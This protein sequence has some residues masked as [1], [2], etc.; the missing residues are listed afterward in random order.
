[1]YLGI[2]IGTSGVKAVVVDDAGEVVDQGTAHL[3]VDRPHPQWAEQNPDDWWRGAEAAVAEIKARAPKALAAVRGA[4]LSGQQHSTTLLDDAERP[5]RPAIL[6][7]DGRSGPQCVELERIAPGLRPITGNQAMPG[8]TAPK[9]LWVA[10]HEP[11][12]FAK[13]RRILLPKDYVRLQMTGEA[14]SDMSDS[15]GTLWLDVANRKWSGELLAACGLTEAQMPRLVEGSQVSAALKDDVAD[16]WGVPRG[17]PVAGGGGDNACGAVGVGVVSTGRA[18]LSI[19]TSGVLFTATPTFAPNPGS[20]MHAFCHA[21]P[22]MWH[23]MSVIMSAA[24][25]LDWVVKLTGAAG[26]T[27]LLDEAEAAD[28]RGFKDVPVFL[29]YLMGDRTPHNDPLATGVFYGL[30]PDTDRAAL[31]LSVLEGVTFAFVDGMEALTDAGTVIETV[32]VIGGGARSAFWGRMLASVLDLTL[33]YH[34]GGEVGPAYGAARLARMAATGEA[35][36][37]VATRPAVAR[38]IHPDAAWADRLAPRLQR[39]R[40]LY[41]TLK[42]VFHGAE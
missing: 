13:T 17:T 12:I 25:C 16:R 26:V 15:A 20:G 24:L 28:A 3:T 5:L 11:E 2:D 8:F 37:T 42:P 9:L 22:G 10:E 41:P 27:A 23:Q 34:D 39:Y 35:P 32:S 36:E 18:F 29:P 14:V 38:T 21:L 1:M 7:N 40:T 30:T 33:D 31:A 19:G 4:G 6:W